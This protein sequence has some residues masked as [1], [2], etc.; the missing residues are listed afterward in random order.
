M[1][2]KL[3]EYSFC[4]RCGGTIGLLEYEDRLRPVCNACGHVIYV[5]PVPATCQTVLKDGSVL[6]VLRAVEPSRGMWCLPGG[7]IEWGESPLEAAKRELAEETALAAETLVLTGVYDSI[8]EVSRHVLLVS[9]LIPEWQGV[10]E[11]GDD[12]AE[13]RWFPLE[14]I[15]PLAFKVHEQALGDALKQEQSRCG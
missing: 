5:N 10:P 1:K 14:K 4:P 2:L 3:P 6:L 13:I 15:P 7:F 9:Y 11:A 8:T 12:A